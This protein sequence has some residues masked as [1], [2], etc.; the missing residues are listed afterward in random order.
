LPFRKLLLAGAGLSLALLLLLANAPAIST[1]AA[2]NTDGSNS[3]TRE[4]SNSLR[5]P[6]N[7]SA[8][9]RDGSFSAE[10]FQA[11][12]ANGEAEVG[13]QARWVALNDVGQFYYT[14]TFE[15]RALNDQG[16][17]WIAVGEGRD[18]DGALDGITGLN[19]P[20]GD[21]RNDGVRNVVTDAQAQY[22]LDQFTT[23]IKPTDES[24]FG[25][26]DFRDGS[27]G[28]LPRPSAAGK[29]VV[30]V[31]NV[32]DDNFY[33]TNNSQ[34]LPYI[35]GFYTSAMI[36]FHDRNVMSIDGWDWLHRTGANPPHDPSS[37]PCTSAPARPFLY[38][39]T[40]AHEY[41]HL[42]HH[43][44]DSDE[45]NWV[46]EGM[47]DF[48]IFLNNYSDPRLRIDQKGNDNHILA[49]EGWLSV[50]H[51]DWNPIPRPDGPENSLTVWE[52]Q[53][54][55]EVLEDY[56]IAYSFMLYLFDHGANQAF[57]T[58]WQHNPL[59]GIEGL[60]DTL[61]QFHMNT[62]FASLFNAFE[63]S[64]LT[65]AFID[66]GAKVY[67]ENKKAISSDSLN[68]TIFFSPDAYATPGAP[69]W[70]ADYIPL[71]K[72]NKLNSLMFDGDEQFVFPGGNDWTVDEDGY[73]TSPDVPGETT[74]DANTD[75]S[76][77]RQ[78]TVPSGTATLTFDHWYQTEDTWDFGFVQVMGS[79]GVFHSLPCTGTVN[80][81]NPDADPSI[82]AQLPGYSG[83]T[84]DPL[85]PATSGTPAA[86]LSA[87]CDLS[88]Y[89]GQT[90]ILAFR[91][92]TDGA[93]NFDGWHIRNIALN[94]TPVD[95]TPADVSDWDNEQFFQP[96]PL[97]FSLTL[98]GIDGK[99]DQYGHV[100]KAKSVVVVHTQLR[101]GSRYTLNENDRQE[102][103]KSDQVYAIVAG[104]PQ[105]EGV[106]VYF[107]YSLIV[108]GQQRADGAGI[109]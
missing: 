40:F 32:R 84:Q 70:G 58:A 54:P 63:I 95:P 97:G 108:N 43:D 92:M 103:R 17:V 36:D 59:N 80:T 20:A 105:D 67:G 71:G 30:L 88:A 31:D 65:D 26:P 45:V 22:L 94:G 107:P 29:Q 55:T 9:L 72:G 13:D 99:V 37:D 49:Y 75:S 91:L 27:T 39:G 42:I 52:D 46:N 5:N 86:P 11:E 18:A 109:H 44:Y 19:F 21:C 10:S 74:Y 73:Y 77:A 90:V 8:L 60:N 35:A 79:D 81:A 28:L 14:K 51:P 15:L 96:V 56:G 23:Q 104:I 41:Q 2:D 3:D 101:N 87:S 83:P 64:T 50:Q 25:P 85:D 12:F 57:F 82:S 66:K 33:D 7:A 61:N 6:D 38:E 76:I 89:A 102:L 69:P 100:T 24:W 34:T 62:S 68:S 98:V 106:D 4:I 16:E 53:G 93:V 47:S 48:A 78:I 1:E